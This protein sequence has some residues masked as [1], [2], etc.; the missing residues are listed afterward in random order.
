MA[1]GQDEAVAVYPLGVGWVELHHLRCL[2]VGTPSAATGHLRP[3][4]VVM[5]NVLQQVMSGRAG[6]IPSYNQPV[7]PSSLPQQ[8]DRLKVSD[9]L[10]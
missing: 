3:L 4:A 1:G 5:S 10:S 9:Q 7:S 2:K 8:L 6:G